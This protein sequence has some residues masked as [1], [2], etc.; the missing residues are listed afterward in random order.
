MPH[1]HQIAEHRKQEVFAVENEGFL[2][3]KDAAQY[4]KDK[5][6][7]GSTAS[8]SKLASVGG[9]PLYRTIGRIPL[10]TRADLDTWARSKLSPLVRSTSEA[11][12]MRPSA[13]Q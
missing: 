11:D 9:G 3:R 8:L 4:L 1:L 6:G 12:A 10:Y 7:I 2:R 5:F 13:R